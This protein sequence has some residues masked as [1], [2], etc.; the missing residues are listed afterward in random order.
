MIVGIVG[1]GLI[2]GSMAKAY[3]EARHTVLVW[4]RN[5]TILDFAMLEGV[6]SAPLDDENM[7]SCD[8]LLVGLPPEATIAWIQAH[9]HTI[10]PKTVVIDLC[11][12]K[13]V[14]CSACF[15]LAQQYGF[16]FVGGH[17]MAG[18]HNSG[19]KYAKSTLF[20]GAPMV[21]VPP[22]GYDMDLL[23]TCKQLLAPAGFGKLSVTT[24]EAHDRMIAFTSQMCHVVSNAYIKSPTARSHKGFSAGS[25]K[26]LT[27]VAWLNADMW[28]EL[29]LENRDFMLQEMDV[30]LA[31]LQAYRDAIAADSFSDLRQLLQ[32]GKEIKEEVDGR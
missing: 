16:T 30:L 8:L 3:A 23:D 29:M 6:V 10:A 32:E 5:R 19:Y 14:V 4:N 31:N 9:A 21:L 11:G 27:R 26:D 1:L 25:Y 22:E 12:T 7:G 2:S 13:R 28:A 24:A 18:T 17:P 15:P 20:K